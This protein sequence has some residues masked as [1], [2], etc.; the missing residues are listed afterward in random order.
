M[1]S[2]RHFLTA[3]AAAGAA[4]AV[5]SHLVWAD[6]KSLEQV[7]TKGINFLAVKG[8]AVDGSY[9]K[10]NGPGI[11]GLVVAGILRNGRKPGDPAVA[12]S[13]KYL[14]GFIQPDGGI[15][16]K[17]SFHKNYET[18]ICI[19]A[20]T[21]A[22]KD[23]R[24]D[25]TLKKADAFIKGIQWDESEGKAKDD[26]NY[27]GAGYGRSARPD[28]SNTAF[29]MDA[30]KATGNDEN[31]EAI[32][33]ALIFV[34][35]CQN[36]ETEHNTTRFAAKNPD[37]GFYYTPVGESGNSQAGVDEK[38]G[39]LRSYASMTYAG[40]KSMIYAGVKPSDPRVKAALTWLQKHYDLKENPGMGQA[41]LFYYYNTFAKAL[42]ATGQDE[43]VD[44]KGTKHDWRKELIA[45]LA[46]RQRAD[47]SWANDE[48]RWMEGDAN[49]VT[50]YALLALSYCK[51]K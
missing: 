37:G 20:F 49:I 4:S 25:K 38:T 34:S 19:L 14:E 16:G 46:S 32:K 8:Q 24:Y 36:L 28:L 17:E 5:L 29:L 1:V 6:D 45:E 12:K 51:K 33:R 3:T 48:K 23:G 10:A 13:L 7:V 2:R 27:G 11:T 30:L 41:G 43:F 40:L 15:Y 31:S 39:G 50:A 9:T 42:S 44:E 35:R 22:N 47:G 21:E 26:V 18:C